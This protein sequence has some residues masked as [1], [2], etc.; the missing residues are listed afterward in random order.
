MDAMSAEITRLVSILG[1]GED[2]SRAVARSSFHLSATIKG[3]H[4]SRHGECFRD[5][6]PGG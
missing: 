1:P 6:L 3:T 4:M 5:G 2:S